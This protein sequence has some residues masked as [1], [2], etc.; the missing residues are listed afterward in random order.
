MFLLA[1]LFSLA[2]LDMGTLITH[3]FLILAYTKSISCVKQGRI[4]ET[5]VSCDVSLSV[6][7]IPAAEVTAYTDGSGH[8]HYCC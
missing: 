7:Q 5:I 8:T 4:K 1:H 3:K 6:V 2:A